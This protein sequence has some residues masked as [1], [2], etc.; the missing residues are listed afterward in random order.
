MGIFE[1]IE[2]ESRFAVI[3]SMVKN[4]MNN[5][6]FLIELKGINGL[7]S[8]YCTESKIKDSLKEDARE[9]Y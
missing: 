6:K 2:N 9:F 3:K 4:S 8:C 1:V 5:L 7:F